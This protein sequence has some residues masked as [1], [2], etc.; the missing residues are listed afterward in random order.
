MKYAKGIIVNYNK[1]NIIHLIFNYF[2]NILLAVYVCF[3]TD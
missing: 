1:I 2:L 3:F